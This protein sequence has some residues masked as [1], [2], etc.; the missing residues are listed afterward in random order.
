MNPDNRILDA[1]NLEELRIAIAHTSSQLHEQKPTLINVWFDLDCKKIRDLQGY[2]ATL[3]IHYEETMDA[4]KI[5]TSGKTRRYKGVNNLNIFPNV[6]RFIVSA[7][8]ADE[9]FKQHNIDEPHPERYPTYN[10]L[11]LHTPVIN[12]DDTFFL[13][14][15]GTRYGMITRNAFLDDAFHAFFS[16]L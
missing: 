3:E 9:Y 16:K 15:I 6:R 14:I 1:E 11:R 13:D 2:D 12:M 8:E 7:E 10:H 5:V 4:V